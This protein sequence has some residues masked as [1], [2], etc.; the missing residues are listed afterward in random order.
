MGRSRFETC[1]GLLFVV[2]FLTPTFGEAS[3]SPRHSESLRREDA[4]AAKGV[5]RQPRGGLGAALSLEALESL[6]RRASLSHDGILHLTYAEFMEEAVLLT[7]AEKLALKLEVP[8]LQ[9]LSVAPRGSELKMLPVDQ[10][11]GPRL[12]HLF[13]LL[14]LPPDSD[15]PPPLQ[16]RCMHCETL[17][18][19]F[20]NIAAA[21]RSAGAVSS[22]VASASC[23]LPTN[24]CRVESFAKLASS[25]AV[26]QARRRPPR[27]LRTCCPCSSRFATSSRERARPWPRCTRLS[28]SPQCF[29]S[30][31]PLTS[32]TS[33]QK[34]FSDRTSKIQKPPP[35]SWI[36]CG[37]ASRERHF[38]SASETKK[39]KLLKTKSLGTF[40]T[41]ASCSPWRQRASPTKSFSCSLRRGRCSSF[42]SPRRR[43]TQE[44]VSTSGLCIGRVGKQVRF[45]RLT[46]GVGGSCLVVR[47][48][49]NSQSL[50]ARAQG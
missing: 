11:G 15:T 39:S 9:R 42:C 48:T 26:W 6:Q 1:V 19:A 7:P 37:S 47:L 29:T 18:K 43:Q 27:S 8:P 40:T 16:G 28:L 22:R 33:Q 35:P 13:V 21:F 14:T 4:R 2:A 30:A 49:P 50:S 41:R 36:S 45:L 44:S 31:P 23:F 3:I 32:M 38:C 12:F 5:F 10:V 25:C 20:R 24:S 17:G 34:T 46:R